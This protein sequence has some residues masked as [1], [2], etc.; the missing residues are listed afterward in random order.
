MS[1]TT[2]HLIGHD[3]RVVRYHEYQNGHSAMVL[4]MAI[5]KKTGIHLPVFASTETEAAFWA[6]HTSPDLSASERTTFRSTFDG[7]V[8][9]DLIDLADAFDEASC[10]LPRNPD[11]V[12]HFPAMAV[13]LREAHAA[14]DV[15]AVGWTQTSVGDSIFHGRWGE[16]GEPEHVPFDLN[17]KEWS[18]QMFIFT[19]DKEET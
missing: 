4:W 17:E 8:C 5:G 2:M 1:H 9:F 12:W 7:A 10:S 19:V 18:D 3:G 14:G 13:H 16:D 15:Q 11:S 6:Q